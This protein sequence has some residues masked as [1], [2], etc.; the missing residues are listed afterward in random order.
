MAAKKITLKN[1]NTFAKTAI[2]LAAGGSGVL[3]FFYLS[4]SGLIDI[5][6]HSG[7]IYGACNTKDPCD[8]YINFTAK[9]DTIIEAFNYSTLGTTNNLLKFDKNVKL[10]T[11]E[12]FHDNKWNLINLS[13]RCKDKYCG[14]DGKKLQTYS[15]K[16][17]KG[18]NYQVKIHVELDKPDK[19]KWTFGALDPFIYPRY[20]DYCENRTV[21]YKVPTYRNVNK[22]KNVI[23]CSDAPINSTCSLKNYTVTESIESGTKTV[24]EVQCK[25]V[26]KTEVHIGQKDVTID[27]KKYGCFVEG[28]VMTC[29]C[30]GGGWNE[31]IAPE[32][33]S[34]IRSGELAKQ[35]DLRDGSVIQDTTNGCSIEVQ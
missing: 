3:L 32:F 7:N 4:S 30:V 17:I 28:Y 25:R 23:F 20:T 29:W 18:Q 1:L 16:F 21:S 5:T 26:L 15:L 33:R 9:N 11:I 10:W 13:A 34:V 12:L 19:I 6:A 8:I 2:A 35:Y 27:Y 24:N 31:G 22:Q 14:S